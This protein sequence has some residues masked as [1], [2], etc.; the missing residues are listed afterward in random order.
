MYYYKLLL[1]FCDYYRHG[2]PGMS[3]RGRAILVDFVRKMGWSGRSSAALQS[4]KLWD[5]LYESS[6]GDIE[7]GC[8]PGQFLSH[9]YKSNG[10]SLEA[11]VQDFIPHGPILMVGSGASL[12]GNAI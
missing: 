4:S 3:I 2:D 5:T 11:S 9:T 8:E 7:W 10:I 12:L 1:V 6:G